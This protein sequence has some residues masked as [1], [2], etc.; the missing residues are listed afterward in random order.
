MEA[1]GV[2]KTGFLPIVKVNC[3]DDELKN[4]NKKFVVRNARLG[5]SNYSSVEIGEYANVDIRA[6]DSISSGTGLN[7][8]SN[9]KLNLRCDKEVSLEGSEVST[10]GSLTVK[11]ETV[12]LSKG[13]SVKAGAALS[14]NAK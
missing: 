2:F 4:C 7:I 10:G 1:L 14:I 3:Y 9:G 11:G 5:Y 8:T 6:V 13:F 12:T